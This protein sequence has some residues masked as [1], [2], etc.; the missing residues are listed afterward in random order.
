MKTLRIELDD[1]D[2]DIPPT[3][4]ELFSYVTCYVAFEKM[5]DLTVVINCEQWADFTGTVKVPLF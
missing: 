3:G 5:T 2:V 1:P 4:K